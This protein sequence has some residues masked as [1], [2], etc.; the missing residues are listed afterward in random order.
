MPLFGKKKPKD[1]SKA[2]SKAPKRYEDKDLIGA[3]QSIGHDTANEVFKVN[4][5]DKKAMSGGATDGYFKPDANMAPA[6]YGVGASRIAQGMGW[7][8]LIP[9]T[10]YAS[11]T[12]MDN[13]T[14]TQ[15]KG[16]VS[17]GVQNS[18]PLGGVVW[19]T[20]GSQ[21]L[22]VGEEVSDVNLKDGHVQKQLNQLQWFD[23]LIGN[24]DRHGGNILIDPAT[25]KVSGIDNDLSFNHSAA[26]KAKTKKGADDPAFAE[27]YGGRDEK[28]L[29]LPSQID[30][31]TAN[32]LLG[33]SPKKLKKMLNPKG[34]DPDTKLSD[35]EL[36][37]TYDRLAKIQEVVGAQKKNGTFVQQWDDNTYDAA[38]NEAQFGNKAYRNYIQRQEAYLT[39]AKDPTNKDQWRPGQRQVDAPGSLPAP[40]TT[41]PTQTA[42]VQTAP[43]QPVAP[44]P[45]WA[46]ANKT[47]GTGG[48]G[49]KVGGSRQR[50]APKRTPPNR[51]MP[52]LPPI[53]ASTATASTA[54][55]ADTGRSLS[56]RV[57][58]TP[59][60]KDF[61]RTKQKV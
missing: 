31:E 48:T 33:L 47:G 6:K 37:Q 1:P 46:N 28:Y 3:P 52:P 12:V 10:Q 18:V 14:P 35:Q 16:A 55:N 38:V 41:A 34:A 27:G 20:Q 60:A 19:E 23:S 54:T 57:L 53:P 40:P 7:G 50:P 49:L 56:D 45:A 25:G 42:P 58:D 9:E 29:G 51:P 11:H 36:Q 26:L 2:K 22:P 24:A 8:S 39:K 4:Y 59:W 13:G 44:K 5:N 61:K 32:T 21:R 17:K 15:K 30:E 43:T